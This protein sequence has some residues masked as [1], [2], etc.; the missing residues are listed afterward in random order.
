MESHGNPRD[1]QM[2]DSTAWRAS[3]GNWHCSIGNEYV[4]N[5]CRLSV[6]CD[7]VAQR[8]GFG[9]HAHRLWETRAGVEHRA[10]QWSTQQYT[11]NS[12]RA[13]ALI[14]HG[15]VWRLVRALTVSMR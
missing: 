7:A 3:E 4:C 6:G 8:T 13:R 11:N 5:A 14:L 9:K 10:V 1:V 15:D 12:T 2:C